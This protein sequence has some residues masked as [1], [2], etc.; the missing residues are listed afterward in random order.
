MQRL[1]MLTIINISFVQK[2]AYASSYGGVDVMDTAAAIF[3]L[4]IVAIMYV[5]IVWY[6]NNVH[7]NTISLIN[8]LMIIALICVATEPLPLI[9]IRYYMTRLLFLAFLIPYLF[10]KNY[11]ISDCYTLCIM[12][13]FIIS[14][15]LSDFED[16]NFTF[17]SLFE[18]SIFDYNII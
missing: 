15:F 2:L 10:N 17:S 16:F 11:F 18:K 14:F 3:F 8:I 13:I 12:C 1:D 7:P 9:Q 5:I 4:L 6:Q